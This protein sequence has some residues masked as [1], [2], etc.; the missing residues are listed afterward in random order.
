MRDG[1]VKRLSSLHA[2]AYR[3]T[4]GR[5]GSRLVDNDMLVL[6]TTG[7]RTGKRHSVP[8]LYLAD[9][10]RLVV[11]ASYGGR[12]EHPQWFRNLE[13]SPVAEVLVGS[14]RWTVAATPMTTE[15]RASWW[16]RIVDA[17]QDYAVYQSR[18]ERTIPVVWLDRV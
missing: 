9:A 13:A 15:E 12:P 18:T 14:Q 17:Y 11:V 1:T 2:M 7:Q 5:L 16:P 3:A 4:R 6:T 10:D 8:L